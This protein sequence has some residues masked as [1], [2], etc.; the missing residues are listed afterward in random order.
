MEVH[1]GRH[2]ECI[3]LPKVPVDVV[4]DW[5]PRAADTRKTIEKRFAVK[6]RERSSLGLSML[7]TAHGCEI[8]QSSYGAAFLLS[9][10][11]IRGIDFTKVENRRK[12]SDEEVLMKGWHENIRFYDETSK[13]IVN[14]HACREELQNFNPHSLEEFHAFCTARWNIEL[15]EEERRLL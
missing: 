14:N 11:R 12:Y 3:S 1:P 7:Y 2:G 4:P 8:E 10:Q 15:P 6:F 5:E 9:R 13:T